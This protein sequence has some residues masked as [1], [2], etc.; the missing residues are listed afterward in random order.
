MQEA[1][2][3]KGG[4][5]RMVVFK[6]TGILFESKACMLDCTSTQP[7]ACRLLI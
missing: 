5:Q 2:R 1:M 4:D 7:C 6:N 3:K